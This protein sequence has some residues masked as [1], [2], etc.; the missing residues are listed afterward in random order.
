MYSV[1]DYGA[2]AADGVRMSAY[3]RALARAVRPGS[4]VLDIGCGTGI[5][6]LMALRA[7]ARHVYAVDTNPSVWLVPQLVAENGLDPARVTIFHRSSYDISLPEKVDVIVSDMRGTSPLC[8]DHVGAVRDA[9]TRFLAP[10]G[11]LIPQRDRMMVG[12]AESFLLEAAFART[13]QSFERLGFSAKAAREAILNYSYSDNPA[14]LSASDLLTGGAA[15]ATL[16]YTTSDGGVLEG[17]VE[18]VA[19]R[20][21][22]AHGLAV[23][24]EATIHEDIGFTTAPGWPLAYGRIFLPL[25]EPVRL[26]HGDRARVTLR[27][28]V[29]GDR[30]AWETTL[31][32]EAGAEKARFRQSTFFGTPTSPEALLRDSS[33]HRPEL[34]ERGAQ[35]RRLLE[36]MDGQRSVAELADALAASLPE[37][38]PARARALDEVRDVVGRYGR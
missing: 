10:G 22:T 15:W 7:G 16:D 4:A 28:D 34:S 36:S 25:L 29:K 23:W 21:G 3:A 9:R 14:P 2:M 13:W 38:S 1:Y 37:G 18:L 33:T 30:W 31:L 32:D 12:L 8:G 24:F 19:T 26:G 11:A 17:D 27:A 20:Q 35:V 6:T 5:F